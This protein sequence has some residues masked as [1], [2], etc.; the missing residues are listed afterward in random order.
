VAGGHHQ[1]LHI[2]EALYG[3]GFHSSS[4]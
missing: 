4:I 2:S 3:Y 1:L